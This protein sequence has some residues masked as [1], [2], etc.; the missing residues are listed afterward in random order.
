MSLSTTS[1]NPKVGGGDNNDVEG[2]NLTVNS[3]LVLGFNC[4]PLSTG[5]SNTFMGFNAAEK[6]QTGNMNTVL[7]FMAGRTFNGDDNSFIGSYV[8]VNVVSCCNETVIGSRAGSRLTFGSAGN[9]IVGASADGTNSSCVGVV[10]VGNRATAGPVDATAIGSHSISSGRGAVALGAGAYAIGQG[11]VNIANRFLGY[12][13]G[14]SYHAQVNADVLRLGGSLAFCTGAAASNSTVR[15][16]MT[17]LPTGQGQG[18]GTD[19]I[20]QSANR[21]RIRFRDEFQ[22]GVLDFTGQHR[23]LASRGPVPMR[24]GHIVRSTGRY[25]DGLS[26][27]DALPEVELC[28]VDD[29]PRVFGVVSSLD[30]CHSPFTEYFI[31]N[32]V[33]ETPK[34]TSPSPR[35]VVNS[36]GEGAVYVSDLN[37]PLRNGD[38][39]TSSRLPGIG[40]RQDS[41]VVSTSTVAKITCDCDFRE[42]I[43]GREAV[44]VALDDG[45]VCA[46]QLVG[47]VY[48]T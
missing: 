16:A 45:T 48:K 34:K 4:A 40:M 33:F 23:C 41:S 15:W 27:D 32:I 12:T 6:T 24:P 18:Q 38:L 36:A 47:C 9:V 2:L 19:V 43:A 8:A 11:H 26:L 22:P 35:V 25:P 28:D 42:S 5:T 21:A 37:G 29:D 20:L 1:G 39:I 7:G 3:S 17:L 30:D 13:F 14:A 10:A 46:T 44:R 31:G